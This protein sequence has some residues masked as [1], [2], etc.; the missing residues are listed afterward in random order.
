MR[1]VQLSADVG[2]HVHRFRPLL[3]ER[4][5]APALHPEKRN[6]GAGVKNIAKGDA[7]NAASPQSVKK[8][9]VQEALLP[10]N[11][12]RDYCRSPRSFRVTPA[13]R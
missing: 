9:E 12:R 6:R 10:L 2:G 4:R 8:V 7:E 3:L 11:R 1:P 5:L 13:G